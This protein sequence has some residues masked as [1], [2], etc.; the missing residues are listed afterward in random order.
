MKEAE[1]LYEELEQ[2]NQQIRRLE[3]SCLKFNAELEKQP[4]WAEFQVNLA[5][6]KE[7]SR[8]LLKT[9]VEKEQESK[10]KE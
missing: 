8:L 4:Y 1:R 10:K 2:R 3:K 9:L 6:E 7:R 5:E